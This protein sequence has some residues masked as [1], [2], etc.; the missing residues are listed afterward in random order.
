MSGGISIG[1]SIAG[2]CLWIGALVVLLTSTIVS[3]VRHPR[4]GPTSTPGTLPSLALI[5]PIAGVEHRMEA[6]TQS[7]LDQDHPDL[8]IVFAVS[9]ERDPALAMLHRLTHDHPDRCRIVFGQWQANRNPKLNNMVGGIE[10]CSAEYL[11]FSDGNTLLYPD[12]AR[13]WQGEAM[14]LGGIV[15]ALPEGVDP[16]SAAAWVECAFLNQHHL[17]LGLTLTWLGVPIVH[18][19]AMMVSRQQ[20]E[21]LG[22]VEALSRYPAEDFAMAQA[23]KA[24]R[25]PVRLSNAT[26]RTPLGARSWRAMISRQRRWAQ[27][28]ATSAPVSLVA[29]FLAAM[30]PSGLAGAMACAVLWPEALWFALLGHGLVWLS[31]DAIVAK[32]R[33]QVISAWTP[34]ASLGREVLIPVVLVA[35]AL[36]TQISWGGEVF[37]AKPRG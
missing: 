37:S 26:A 27:L 34:L 18:G 11:F 14:A 13:R 35:G 33:G 9:S 2:L 23:A 19:K 17:R 3:V 36:K 10:A 22:G 12:S 15:S 5:R 4:L 29:E 20:F 24:N 1:L 32:L 8:D 7:V 28:R 21:A 6:V 25:I 30:V 16:H 31:C